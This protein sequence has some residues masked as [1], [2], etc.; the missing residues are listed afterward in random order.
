MKSKEYSETIQ[1]VT[2]YEVDGNLFTHEHHA[3]EFLENRVAEFVRNLFIER[4][5]PMSQAVKVTNNLLA[6]RKHLAH[7]LN[8]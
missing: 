4:E 3:Q 1:T 7:I 5:L 2:R 6:Q 8:F